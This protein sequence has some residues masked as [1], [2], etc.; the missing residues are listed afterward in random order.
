MVLMTVHHNMFLLWVIVAFSV[1]LFKFIYVFEVINKDS[2]KIM[3]KT[4][5]GQN[6]PNE[7]NSTVLYNESYND[8]ARRGLAH[9]KWKKKKKLAKEK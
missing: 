2:K 7:A 5:L 4:N 3:E 1:F 8:K 9:K 6:L